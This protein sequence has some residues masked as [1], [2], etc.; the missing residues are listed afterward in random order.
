MSSSPL[1][2]WLDQRPPCYADTEA[3]GH[4]EDPGHLEILG[5]LADLNSD[6]NTF[7]VIY[8]EDEDLDWSIS[9]HT[10]PGAFGGYE[11][12]QRDAATREH[13]TT[14]QAHHATITAHVLDW[15]S[16]R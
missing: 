11:I 2:S 12:E 10:S 14:A 4:V 3:G 5:M 16:R 15:L 9:V 7:F 8:P 6:D 1:P 13:T